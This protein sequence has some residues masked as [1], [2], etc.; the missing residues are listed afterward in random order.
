MLVMRGY[1]GLDVAETLATWG[2]VTVVLLERQLMS[3]MWPQEVAT[4]YEKEYVMRGITFRTST[5]VKV[6]LQNSC[7]NSGPVCSQNLASCSLFADNVSENRSV[8]V[9][10]R[11]VYNAVHIKGEPPVRGLPAISKHCCQHQRV[12]AKG[13]HVQLVA[14]IAACRVM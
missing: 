7:A 2:P 6:R 11:C 3:R 13:Y 12:R 4:R 5:M 14:M 9:R 1:I 10:S 8:M